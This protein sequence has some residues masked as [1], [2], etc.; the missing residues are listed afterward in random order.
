V[1]QGAARVGDLGEF[2]DG[3]DGAGFVVGVHDR[4]QRCPLGDR[5]FQFGGIDQA[6]LVDR[7]FSDPESVQPPHGVAGGEHGGMFGDL[8][9]DVVAAVPPG[10]R[11]AAN[12]KRVAVR[13][14][15]GEHDLVRCAAQEVGDRSSGV[16]DGVVGAAAVVVAAGRITEVVSQKRY[17]G[18]YHLR[19][20]RGRGVVVKVDRP[21]A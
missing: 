21:F 14:S 12:G 4:Y 7:K 10:E 15:S 11:S 3:L 5:G 19:F 18:V 8:C 20:D 16:G 13:A 1:E 17:A 6:V 2:T 9:D